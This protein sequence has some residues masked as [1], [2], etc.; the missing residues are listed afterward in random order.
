MKP[1]VCE[2]CRREPSVHQLVVKGVTFWLCS[3]CVPVPLAVAS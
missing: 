2:S 1:P 3:R